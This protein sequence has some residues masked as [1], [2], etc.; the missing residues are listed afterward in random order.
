MSDTGKL[1]TT[2]KEKA[3]VLNFFASVFSDN[4]LPHSLQMFGLVGGNQGSKVL[5]TE[6]EGQVHDHMRNLNI[7]KSMGPSEMHPRV[8]RELADVVTKPLSILEKSW[9]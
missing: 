1:V 9:Q 7:H 4:C 2:D 6:R 8:L 5:P 3:E